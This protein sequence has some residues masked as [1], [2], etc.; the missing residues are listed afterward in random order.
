MNDD[1]KVYESTR[2]D[3]GALYFDLDN[4]EAEAQER[5]L[6][7]GI[8]FVHSNEIDDTYSIAYNGELYYK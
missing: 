6:S 4:A 8:W 2:P 5:S 3:D 7:G 1:W